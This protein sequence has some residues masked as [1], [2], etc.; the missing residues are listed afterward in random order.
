MDPSIEPADLPNRARRCLLGGFVAAYVASRIPWA[1]AEPVTDADMAPFM[2]LSALL[3]GRQ[4]L[5]AAQ[6]K[7]LYAA[8]VADD[9]NFAANAKSLLESVEQRKLDPMALQQ[10]LDAEKSPWA[11]VPRQVMRAWYLGIVGSGDKARCLA[12]E[13]ALN[14]EVVADVLKPPTYAYGA[15]GS[16]AR[17]PV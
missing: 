14:A 16:W 7:R 8:L 6:A 15:Y 1:L 5:D 10:V 4:S 3:A 13:T 2:A 9:P 11:A 12:F 17:K